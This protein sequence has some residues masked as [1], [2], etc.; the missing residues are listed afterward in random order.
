MGDQQV[1]YI[2]IFF[3]L[4]SLFAFLILIFIF[5]FIFIYA[6]GPYTYIMLNKY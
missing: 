2:L 6:M 4:W 5:G 1:T 3:I